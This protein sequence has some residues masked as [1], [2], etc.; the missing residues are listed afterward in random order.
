MACGLLLPPGM[1]TGF[2]LPY[3]PQRMDFPWCCYTV[4]AYYDDI[5]QLPGGKGSGKKPCG[6]TQV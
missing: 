5:H 3:Q 2:R 1:V 6:Y 4:I